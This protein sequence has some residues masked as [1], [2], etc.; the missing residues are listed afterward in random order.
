VLCGPG[1]FWGDAPQRALTVDP[2]PCRD[3]RLLFGRELD[4]VRLCTR[5]TAECASPRCM[6]AIGVDRVVAALDEM[7][8]AR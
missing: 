8:G 6:E 5:T 1:D 3:E 4:W 2:F 7:L